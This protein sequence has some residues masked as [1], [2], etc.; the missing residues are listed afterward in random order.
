MTTPSCDLRTQAFPP[1]L[2]DAEQIALADRRARSGTPPQAPVV[3]V[4]LSGG[5]IRSATFCLGLFQ[6]LA[7]QRLIRRIDILSTVSGGGYFGSFLGTAFARDHASADFVERELADNNSWSVKWLRENGRFLSP[8]GAGD[9]WLTA[10]TALRN[11]AALHVVL[12]TFA[13]LILGLGALI[14]ADLCTARQTSDLWAQ[15]ELFFWHHPAF[16]IWWSPWLLLPVIP[17]LLFMAPTGTVYWLTQ[18]IPLMAAVRAFF[19]L[20]SAKTRGMTSH[21]FRGRA[22]NWLTRIFMLGFV[23]AVTL[24]GFAIIDSLG[25]TAYLNWAARDF[26][27]P[28]IWATLTGVGAGL[29]GFATKIAIYVERLLGMRRGH[30]PSR[31]IALVCALGW[32]LLIVLAL[33]VTAC[34]FAWDWDLV[35]TGEQFQ[36]MSGGWQLMLAVAVCFVASWFFSRAFGFVNLSSMQQ[37]YAARLS[38]AYLGATN[39]ERRQ[40]ANHSMTDLMPGDDIPIEDYAPHHNGGPLHLI[41]STVNETISGKTNIERLDRKGV[42]MAVGPCGLSVGIESHALWATS[43]IQRKGLGRLQ[44]LWET[45][46][47]TIAPIACSPDG[48]RFHALC[49]SSQ[50]KESAASDS[51]HQIEAISLGRWVAISGAAFT[52]GTG[53]HTSMGL[54]LLLGLGN[55]RLGYW[56]DSGIQPGKSGARSHRPTFL[57]LASRVISRVLPVQSCLMNEFFARFHG[58]ARRHWYLSDGGHFENTG[59]YELIRRRVPFIICSD[60]GQDPKYELA[61]LA[62]LVRKARI[63]FGAEIQLV[64]RRGDLATDDPGVQFPMPKLEDIVHPNLLDVIG[65]PEDFVPLQTNEEDTDESG[66]SKSSRYRFA[67]C[68]ALLARVH[69]LDTNEFSWLLLLKPSLMGDEAADVIQYQRTRP[70]FPQ[71]PTSDQYFDEAQWESYRKLGEHIATELFTPP[72]ESPGAEIPTWSPSEMCPP[73]LPFQRAKPHSLANTTAE[74][75]ELRPTTAL[76]D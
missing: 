10:A 53:A 57:E 55:V 47:R 64:R 67:R 76:V 54:S 38:R 74:I 52:T 70:L 69:Y 72:S 68:H 61:D 17:V 31:V 30:I 3:G 39:P 4:A 21:E 26:A 27:F 56:W 19:G 6:A 44:M 16:G 14:R 41:N 20:F 35:W 51:S 60:G 71:E 73:P 15:V 8:N 24:L 42:A 23:G 45:R 66:A 29:F 12:L 7:R 49:D 65:T 1:E 58:P 48:G 34:G 63:D 32:S 75:R 43:T 11:W 33:S 22:Q 18:W 62:N 46:R 50:A 25:Q 9:N 59:C 2:R 28:A 37:L 40:H 5:G 13:F 36:T